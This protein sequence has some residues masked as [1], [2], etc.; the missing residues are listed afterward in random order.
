MALVAITAAIGI[1]LEATGNNGAARVVVSAVAGF[2]A[3]L[4]FKGMVDTLREGSFGIDILAVT[5]IA[6]T[7]I[8]GEYWAA[9]VV[10]LMLTG[11]EGLEDYAENRAGAELTSLLEG[12]PTVAYLKTPEGVK[13]IDVDAV[14]IGNRLVVRPHEIVPVDCL[15]ESDSA[16]LDESQLT[17]ESLP[18][19]HTRGEAIMSG[20]LNGAATI[21]VVAKATAA[22]SQYQRIVSLVNEAR[23]SKA[24][25]VRLADRVAV[26]FTLIAF[27]IAGAAWALSGDPMRFAQVLV[28]ATPC[29]LIIAAPVAFMAGMSRAARTGLIVKNAGTIEKISKVK[30]VAFD[31]TGTLTRGEPQIQVVDS[32][33]DEEVLLRY[34]ASAEMYSSHPL[35]EAIVEAAGRDVPH[36]VDAQE[37]PAQGVQATVDGKVVRVGKYGFV[38]GTGEPA[39][40]VAEPG[41]SS[42]YVSIDGELAGRI[43]MSDPIRPET[44]TALAA[45]REAGIAN[46]AML[47][48]DAEETAI[49]VADELGI[50]TVHGGLLPEDKVTAIRQ[51]QPEPVM[52]VG[53]GVNDAPVLAASDV[54][55]AM[56]ARGSAAAVE[57]ADV[58]IMLD[59]LTRIPRLLLACQ[60][61]MRIAW[62]AIAI[63]VGFSVVLML[64]GASGIMPA[65]VGAWMQELVDL[66]CILWALLAARP[67]REELALSAQFDK[68]AE[69]KR[70]LVGV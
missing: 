62:Q 15:L 56:G 34:A 36:P 22:D 52:M 27:L 9:L 25:F 14:E 63:G 68:S 47:T 40:H 21:E 43:E 2:I 55:V 61:T 10:C 24:P 64:I 19:Q 13:E 60:R 70:E 58:V 50:D 69:P 23:E 11:G 32:H 57:S 20:A 29:P 31:K 28:V 38:T 5:A 33:M 51:L 30:T 4:Q 16:L 26:P 67:S 1:I 53:D 17:G 7:I 54:G 65:F 39:T 59:D 37:I 45:V 44:P 48:G 3:I 12:A 35:A 46:T 6:S 8:V 66:V 49:R 42:V 18:V 41:R